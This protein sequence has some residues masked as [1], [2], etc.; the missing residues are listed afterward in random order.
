MRKHPHT[1]GLREAILVALG[2]I[3]IAAIVAIKNLAAGS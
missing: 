3:A 2:A 1:F